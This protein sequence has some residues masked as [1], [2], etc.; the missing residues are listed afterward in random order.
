MSSMLGSILFL[1]VTNDISDVSSGPTTAFQ[2]NNDGAKLC[3]II[4][5]IVDCISQQVG[6]GS[7]L[8]LQPS[9]AYHKCPIRL[10]P[11][12]ET[13]FIEYG[14]AVTQPHADDGARDGDWADVSQSSRAEEQ[15][16]L[17]GGIRASDCKSAI[18]AIC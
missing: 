11:D 5:G 17:Y 14:V 13:Y 9:L 7:S 3:S 1:F 8:V 18:R 10:I 16:Q 15:E 4:M 6:L 2:R 12:S